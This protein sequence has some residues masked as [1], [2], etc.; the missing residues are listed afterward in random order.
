MFGWIMTGLFWLIVI[1]VV[2]FVLGKR[3]NGLYKSEEDRKFLGVCG[4]IGEYLGIDPTIVRLIWVVFTLCGGSG[5]LVYF[6]AALIMPRRVT[7]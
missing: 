1:A 5:I 4:G 6:L 3:G 2:V 7:R